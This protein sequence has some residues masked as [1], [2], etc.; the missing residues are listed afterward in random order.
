M[1]CGKKG[2]QKN[3][4]IFLEFICVHTFKM[5]F[6]FKRNRGK[7]RLLWFS[8]AVGKKLMLCIEFTLLDSATAYSNYSIICHG[9]SVLNMLHIQ[10]LSLFLS[11]HSA[12]LSQ[13]NSLENLD[14][15][16]CLAS[17]ESDK[18]CGVHIRRN[19]ILY[20][21]PWPYL[22]SLLVLVFQTFC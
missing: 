6:L 8:K 3:P 15:L 14:N 10:Q 19:Y 9:V 5:K 17:M 2:K 16:V 21:C 22:Q 18:C 12:N 20:F 1:Q 4:I 7:F 11:I 13:I